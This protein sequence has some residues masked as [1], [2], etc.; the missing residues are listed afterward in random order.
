MQ[1]IIRNLGRFLLP[2]F[3][4]LTAGCIGEDT[5][6]A[7]ESTLVQVGESAPDFTVQMFDGSEIRLSDLRGDVVLLTFFSSWCP[8]C[9]EELGVLQE[10][11][12]DR[13]G[14]DD[15]HLLCISSGEG[16]ET[17]AAFRAEYGLT[18]PMGLDPSASIYGLYATEQVPRNFLL[19]RS[20]RIVALTVGYEVSEFDALLEILRLQ[21]D[22]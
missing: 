17:I 16:R 8:E 7:A 11:V 12:L 2:V 14:G 15:F 13:F 1:K 22:Q 5:P 21:L 6:S 20:G 9:R 18:Y 4:L 19:D 3:S 10:R